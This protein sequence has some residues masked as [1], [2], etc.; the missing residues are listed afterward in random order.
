MHHDGQQTASSSNID[1]DGEERCC[2]EALLP[3]CDVVGREN[4]ERLVVLTGTGLY[5]NKFD[6]N[7]QVTCQRRLRPK[8]YESWGI[9]NGTDRRL[10]TIDTQPSRNHPSRN[11]TTRG[12][13][14]YFSDAAISFSNDS[15]KQKSRFCRACQWTKSSKA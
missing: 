7:K 4:E 10:C 1:E 5:Q 2:G 12:P 9:L 3:I 13:A 8:C 11:P 15:E 14:K 6:Q